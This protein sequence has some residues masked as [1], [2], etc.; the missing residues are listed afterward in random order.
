M[1]QRFVSIWFPH[2][3]T[4]WTLRRQ[5]SLK[6]KPF[7]L[8]IQEH[9]RRVVK[10]VNREAEAQ[11]VYEN[12]VV[13]DC[14][15]LVP[16]LEVL[17]YDPFRPNKLLNSFAEWF[18]RYTPIVT[19]DPPS[20][21][22]LDASGCTHL[23][24]GEENYLNDIQKKLQQLLYHSKCA[25]SDTP[26]TAWACCRFGTKGSVL[27][28]QP[29]EETKALAPLPAAALRIEAPIAERFE[30]LG[31]NTIGKFMDLPRTALRRR[32]GQ[33]LIKRLDQALGMELELL[34][35]F[36]AVVPYQERLPCMEPICTVPAIG[37][38]LNSLLESICS[39]LN[40][41]NKGLRKCLFKCYRID[42]NIQTIEVGTNRPSRNVL[43][44][45]KL[46]EI[47]IAQLEPGLGYELFMLEAP[48]VEE[49][50]GTQDALWTVSGANEGAFAELLDRL[51]GRSGGTIAHYLPAEHYWPERSVKES[52]S[53]NEK[54]LAD[55]RV[56]LPRPLHLLSDP[57]P[58]EA[59]VPVPDYPPLAFIYKSE[60]HT[61]KKADGPE[62]IEQE[63]WI[64]GGLYRD[65]YFVEDENGRR[66]W[67]FRA[68]DNNSGDAKW[69]L[70]GF[71]S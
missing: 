57:E 68:G 20:G 5:P 70:H 19:I 26:G 4:D 40:R 3:M 56:D 41:E 64:Q 29:G 21:L 38:A 32:F 31:L 22:F 11:G 7:A 13:A 67:L 37:I 48:L 49:L 6:D 28:V 33:S 39:R 43:H 47:K 55:W 69:F 35:P 36:K 24:G 9:N 10:A 51:N 14:K 66:Y 62:R 54:P 50:E 58:I 52:P 46:F 61:V 45:F 15:S 34:E 42:G 44:L 65:Y 1:N 59:V 16:T 12:M 23:W 63:W 27:I 30:K 2:L 53:V 17:D 60:R 18:L 25:I 8:A 71:F